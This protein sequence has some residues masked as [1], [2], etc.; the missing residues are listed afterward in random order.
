M[1][2]DPTDPY[3][4][5]TALTDGYRAGTVKP[6]QIVQAHLDR[7]QRLDPAIGAFQAI[8]ATDAMQAAEAADALFAAGHRI[9]PFHGIPFVL[10][11]IC[12]VA[13]RITTSGSA[14]TADRISPLTGTVAHRLIAAGGILIGKTKTVEYALG[15]WGTN[16]HMGTPRN[17]WDMNVHRVPGGS[18]SGTGAGVAAGFAVCGVGTDT[19]GSV[20]LPAAFCGVTGLKLTE[21]RLPTDGILPLSHTLDTP[22]PLARSVENALIMYLVMAG[23]EGWAIE[24]D[25]SAASGPF[26]ALHAGVGGLRLGVLDDRERAACGQDVLDTYDAA[27]AALHDRGAACQVFHA[28]RGY[29]ALTSDSGRL[30]AAEGYHHHGHLYDDPSLPMDEDVRTRMLGGKGISADDYM[31]MMRDRTHAAQAYLGAM[32]G[33]DAILTPTMT[34]SAPAVDT[35]DQAVSPA[36]FT[37]HVNYMGLC[38]LAVPSGLTGQGLPGSLQIVARANCEDMAIRIGAALEHALPAMPNPDLP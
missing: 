35:V 22:G 6:S 37:R 27:V 24:R 16:Q 28:P 21:G 11:D 19:G 34:V 14:A 10:K 36:H 7:I 23:V 38:A 5:L 20:R 9:G 4:A 15:G 26:A 25:R 31:A 8:Y 3:P 29:D 17:P 18:S 32:E 12:D 2:I 33:F 13:G 30:I 1:S